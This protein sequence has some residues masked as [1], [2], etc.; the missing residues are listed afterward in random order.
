MKTGLN[1][2]A[3]IGE[4]L[5]DKRSTKAKNKEVGRSSK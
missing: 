3:Q 5:N 1:E 2:K 4:E